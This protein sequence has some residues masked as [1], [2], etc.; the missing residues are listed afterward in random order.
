VFLDGYGW[1]GL[2][3]VVHNSASAIIEVGVKKVQMTWSSAMA[4]SKAVGT[5]LKPATAQDTRGSLWSR[6]PWV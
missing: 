5:A 6:M 1:V 4:E 3:W 2:G